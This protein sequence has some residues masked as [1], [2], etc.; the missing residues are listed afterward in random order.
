MK[1]LQYQ[2]LLF[3]HHK[4]IQQEP[5]WQTLGDHHLYQQTSGHLNSLSYHN[6]IIGQQE[7]QV[8]QETQAAMEGNLMDLILFQINQ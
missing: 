2:G 4:C 6:Q 1:A 3:K 7:N 8:I 5:M